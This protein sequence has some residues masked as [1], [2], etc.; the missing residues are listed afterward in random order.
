MKW[1]KRLIF[2]VISL[3]YGFASLDY[4]YLS[5]GMMTGI[6]N[7]SG[8]L[9]SRQGGP[10]QLVGVAMILVWFLL[11]AGYTYLIKSAAPKIDLIEKDA[12]TGEQKV[13]KKWFD[14]IFQ[15]ALIITGA[16]LRWIYL[17]VIYFPRQ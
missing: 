6:R 14:M 3:I 16:A 9:D 10:M 13:H 7:I 15:Y 5:F 2:S 1:W 8:K 11:L 4:L 17:F 12:R